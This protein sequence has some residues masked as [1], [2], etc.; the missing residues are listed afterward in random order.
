MRILN[1]HFLGTPTLPPR[2]LAIVSRWRLRSS[3]WPTGSLTGALGGFPDEWFLIANMVL[4]N[5]VEEW[6][7]A[8]DDAPSDHVAP[9]KVQAIRP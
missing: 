3:W 5:Y 2:S 4:A 6:C 9:P 7:Q 8:R 1:K